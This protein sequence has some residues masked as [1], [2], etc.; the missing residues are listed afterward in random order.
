MGA[1]GFEPLDSDAA[2][3]WIGEACFELSEEIDKLLKRAGPAD[4]T[5]HYAE[6]LRAAAF[7]VEEINF[8]PFELDLHARLAEALRLILADTDYIGA[9]SEPEKVKAAIQAQIDALSG[10][11]KSTTLLENLGCP[12]DKGASCAEHG[13]TRQAPAP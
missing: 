6:E 4:F 9:W 11:P 8:F 1:W 2:L 13:Y 5:S 12:C 3:D 10:G 7:V